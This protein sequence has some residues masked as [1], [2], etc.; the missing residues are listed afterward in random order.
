MTADSQDHLPPLKGKSWSDY[1]LSASE[2]RLIKLVHHCLKVSEINILV[3]IWS[4]ESISQLV[5]DRHNELS[6]EDSPTCSKVYPLLELLLSEW[7][8]LLEDDTYAPVHDALRA[9]IAGLE[10][11]YR[12]AD[13]TSA[14]FISHG[15]CLFLQSYVHYFKYCYSS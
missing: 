11:Y 1:K 10:K 4:D 3:K 2:W 15:V 9:G 12:K 5:A 7:E 13:D 8:D 6:V 14:Y